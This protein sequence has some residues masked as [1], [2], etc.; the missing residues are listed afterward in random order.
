M[1]KMISTQTTSQSKCDIEYC[2][3]CGE[4]VGKIIEILGR[5]RIVPILCKCQ[6]DEKRK[7]A[8]LDD[9]KEKQR[10]L[11]KLRRYSLMDKKFESCRFET[12]DHQ[13]DN[14]NIYKL[15]KKYCENWKMI[16]RDGIGITLMGEPGLGKT[17]IAFCIANELLDNYVPVIAVSTIGIINRIY[18]SYGRY[19]DVG[20]VEIIRSLENADLLIL[21]DLGAEHSSPKGKEKQ[22]IYS[23]IDSRIRNEKPM[24]VTTNLDQEGL[25]K[26]LAGEDGV[27]RT[28]DRLLAACPVI[29]MTGT[30]RRR[31]IGNEK[32]KKLMGLVK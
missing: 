21:D 10:R 22:I 25:R 17:H 29:E 14:Q 27:E 32:R 15:A 20:E 13:S 6:S 31:V 11:E 23:L 30:P 2:D 7:F 16:K 19:G 28:F 12:Y 9:K 8:E 1:E 26:K 24:I 5:E 18:E 4:P 3:K